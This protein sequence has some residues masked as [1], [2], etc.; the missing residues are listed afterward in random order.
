MLFF[1]ACFDATINELEL[2][3][4]FEPDVPPP[5]PPPDPAIV[6]SNA[7]WPWPPK[8]P[9]AYKC[10]AMPFGTALPVGVDAFVEEG[11]S[12]SSG[13]EK[14]SGDA[15]DETTDWQPAAGCGRANEWSIKLLPLP[16]LLFCIGTEAPMASAAFSLL[17][18]GASSNGGVPAIGGAIGGGG[19]SNWKF[20]VDW[21]D[22][23]GGGG[24]V[25]N[26]GG[27]N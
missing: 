25:P 23:G 14:E 6:V 8:C 1:I 9:F 24:K 16:L 21:D 12:E 20:A 26:G 11:V 22:G 27:T 2:L 3:E 18:N 15:P 13:L 10:P 19:L 5:P 7:I 17:P 4:Q